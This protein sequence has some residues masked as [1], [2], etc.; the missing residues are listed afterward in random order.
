MDVKAQTVE[1]F[2]FQQLEKVAPG[3]Y[4]VAGVLRLFQSKLRFPCTHLKGGHV[5]RAS[6]RRDY[7]LSIFTFATGVIEIKCLYNCGLK[8][9][10]DQKDLIDSFNELYDLPTTN[11]PAT[12]ECHWLVKNGE[13][14][15]IDPGPA[16]TC[17]D[18]RRQ[19]IRESNDKFLMYINQGLE[20]G[21]VKHGDPIL[22]AVLPHPDPIEAP[23]SIVE[24]GII[25][26]HYMRNRKLAQAVV[27]ALDKIPALEPVKTKIRKCKTQS[28]KRG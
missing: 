28:R 22:G 16:P 7:N 12:S 19:G 6:M 26:D 25:L 27:T 20:S 3:K 4:T 14:N 18:E 13:R 15:P 17:S 5:G 2:L 23:D 1:Q 9:R 24:R 21:R 10:S 8:I 11:S